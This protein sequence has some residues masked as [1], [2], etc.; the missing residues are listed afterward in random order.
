MVS[1]V[2]EMC[3]YEGCSTQASYASVGSNKAD[4]CSKHAR[5]EIVGVVNTNYNNEGCSTRRSYGVA[6][7]AKA[8]FGSEHPRAVM[9]NM[10]SKRCGEVEVGCCKWAIHK[11]HTVDEATYCREHA[12]ARNTAAISDTAKLNTGE[13]A[14]GRGPTETSG[15]SVADSRGTKRTRA[16]FSGPVAND[17]VGGR[18]NAG[19]RTP[20][21]S[22]CPLSTTGE[23]VTFGTKAGAG[24][25][26][27]VAVPSPTHSSDEMSE[28]REFAD[29]SSRWTSARGGR[30]FVSSDGES[31]GRTCSSPI[32]V[33]GHLGEL[34]DVAFEEA[35]KDPNV[36]FE[37]GV[38]SAYPPGSET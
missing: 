38:S 30:G 28:C 5:M 1:V 17:F 33:P 10:G 24:M 2:N 32:V 35:R 6:G 21:L 11:E 8:E 31:R 12:S 22:G 25:K 16:A 23:K 4:V 36:K 37:L 15:E 20:L 34:D 13:G 7:S 18:R 9:V 19:V 27:E 29:S 14:P 26:V 3:G